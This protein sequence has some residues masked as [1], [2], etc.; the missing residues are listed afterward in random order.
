MKRIVGLEKCAQR[1][2]SSIKGNKKRVVAIFG[3]WKTAE[4]APLH[5]EY[6]CT[7]HA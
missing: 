7:D 4:T 2:S 6:V 1:F 5:G 3:F